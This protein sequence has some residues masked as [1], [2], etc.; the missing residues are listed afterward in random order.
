MIAFDFTDDP[1]PECERFGMR[2]VHAKNAPALRKPVDQD[3]LQFLP[4][5][6][7]IVALEI[8]RI[9]VLVLLGRV[10]GVLHATVGTMP[11]PLGMGANVGMIGSALE[12]DIEGNVN[13]GLA[14][15][16]DEAFEVLQGAQL[17]H[18]ILLPPS[19]EPMAH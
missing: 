4:Q 8:E 14:C 11:E 12:C 13:A 5:A 16:P 15:L 18:D 9:N 19:I 17:R 10:F 7:P 1:P 3:T 6:P 2:I